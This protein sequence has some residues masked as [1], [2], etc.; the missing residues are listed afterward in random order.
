MPI[1]QFRF[2]EGEDKLKK[3]ESHPGVRWG[4]C[5][6]CGSSMLYDSDDTPNTIY[7]TVASLDGPLDREPDSHVSYEEKPSW[8]RAMH[9]L[10][11][12]KGKTNE[13]IN[14]Y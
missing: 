5:G 2:L 1:N 8:L 12:F 14:E 3:F 13:S 6:E 9:A 10:P 11:R 4:F 7:M